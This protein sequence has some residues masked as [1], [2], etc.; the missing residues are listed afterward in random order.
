M[1]KTIIIALVLSLDA[2][3]VALALEYGNRLQFKE[4][5]LL[6]FSFGFFQFLCILLGAMLGGYIN[7]NLFVITDY[8]AGSIILLLGLY[9]IKEGY[10]KE[11]EAEYKALNFF[12]IMI[13][14]ITVSIDA[15]G[16]GFSILHNL[17]LSIVFSNALIIGFT[18]FIVTLFAIII[19]NKVRSFVLIERYV[20]FFAGLILIVLG[21]LIII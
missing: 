16:V 6:I 4:K 21:L 13:L 3:G 9:L 15:L 14:G 11:S 1:I 2:F 7:N 5:L 17:S 8:L 10:Q 18:T 19:A 12:T 20:D